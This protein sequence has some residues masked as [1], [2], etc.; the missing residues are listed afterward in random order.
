MDESGESSRRRFL[1]GSA[2]FAGW[3]LLAFAQQSAFR[4]Q[5]GRYSSSMSLA[6]SGLRVVHAGNL[7]KGIQGNLRQGYRIEGLARAYQGGELGAPRQLTILAD[8]F[9]PAAD[10]PGQ[11]KGKAYFN[12]QWAVELAAG[13]Q[14]SPLDELQGRLAGRVKA[15]LPF[16]PVAGLAALNGSLDIPMSRMYEGA[17]SA[18]FRPV[19]GSGAMELNPNATGMMSLSLNLWPLFD[20][21]SPN[22]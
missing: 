6:L 18:A 19:R 20:A 3:P 4:T 14:P 15:E 8:I 1:L 2:L 12:G 16:D 11:R 22:S 17:G 13:A 7:V 9:S 10:M 5:Q 21:S